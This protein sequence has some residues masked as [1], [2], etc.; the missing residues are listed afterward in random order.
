MKF[1]GVMI[2][3]ENPQALGA[4]YT[5]VL[6]KPGFQQDD[7]FG[8]QDG[9]QIMLGGHSEVKGGNSTPARIMLTLEVDDVKE[10][11]ETITGHGADV[12]AEPYK[13]DEKQEMWLA[14]VSDP[15]G[16]YIQLATA[17]E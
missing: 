4:F 7:W 9:A 10:A 12:V 2:G 1:S 15:D 14:T 16:N 3:S 17:W 13:P 8:W 6:G 11:F 5:K